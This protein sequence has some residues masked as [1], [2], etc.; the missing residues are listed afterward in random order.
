[1]TRRLLDSAPAA[2]AAG[3]L[4]AALLLSG[5]AVQGARAAA[6][7]PSLTYTADPFAVLGG[8]ARDAGTYVHVVQAGGS[9]ALSKQWAVV[10]QGA[11]TAGASLSEKAVGDIAGVQGAFNNGDQIWL[12]QLQATGTFKNGTISLGRLSSGDSFGALPVMGEFANS[13]FASNG[14]AISVNDPGRATSP[15]SSWGVTGSLTVS[16][17]LTLR[18][19][20]FLSDPALFAGGFRGSR[21]AFKP[22][23]GV[24]G[25]AEADVAV[26]KGWTFGVGGY[27]DSADISTF[28]G[29]PVGGNHGYYG[30]I[31]GALIAG[32][33]ASDPAKLE[34]FAVLQGAP[35]DRSL[36]PFFAMGGLVLRGPFGARPKDVVAVAFQSGRISRFAGGGRET[37]L[38]ANYRITLNDH[39]G[40]RPDIQWVIGPNGRDSDAVVAGV[41]IEF[42]L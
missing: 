12:Y 11:W 6:I 30:F 32:A 39:W 7:T 25:F 29:R 37:T 36:Q 18:G 19:G 34:G 40:I 23:R 38:E 20:A 16:P 27:A 4:V 31:D 24:L 17:A 35:A 8:D 42:G 21:L 28:A 2:P 15:A 41:Q 26:A 3:V 14:G 33:K 10:V 9:Y 5:L 1:M 22:N 13:A